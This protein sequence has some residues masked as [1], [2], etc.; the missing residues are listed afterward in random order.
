MSKSQHPPLRQHSSTQIQYIGRWTDEEY[1]RFLAATRQYGRRWKK[2]AASLKTR[3]AT[4]VRTH[5]LKFDEK[6][7]KERE[8]LE[9]L[10]EEEGLSPSTFDG[11]SAEFG[12]INGCQTDDA[13][14]GRWSAEEHRL[15]LRA[16]LQHGK[17][18]KEISASLK[19]RSALQVRTHAQKFYAKLV[20]ANQV[21]DG[22]SIRKNATV[23]RGS[24]S[25]ASV[26]SIPAPPSSPS[27]HIDIKLGRWSEEEHCLFLVAA[28]EHGRNWKEIARIVETHTSI[29]VRT[30]AQKWYFQ[31][32]QKLQDEASA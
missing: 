32:W 19:T 21:G 11:L 30:H 31:H 2:I 6:I 18:W 5:A 4:Q 15:F 17:G 9:T 3:T 29:Q 1:R 12:P 25:S 14:N 22:D 27:V 7:A 8:N 23:A 20:N 10:L 26:V 13:N 16:V 24:S 28:L